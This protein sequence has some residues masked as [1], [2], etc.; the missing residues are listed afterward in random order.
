MEVYLETMDGTRHIMGYAQCS[1]PS[2]FGAIPPS[3]EKLLQSFLQ[4]LSLDI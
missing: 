4:S 1:I 3:N 2:I